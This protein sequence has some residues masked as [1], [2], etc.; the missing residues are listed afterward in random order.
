MRISDAIVE[1]LLKA[2]GKFSD[3][4][5]KPL[6]EQEKTE[7]KPLQDIVIKNSV[8]TEKELTKLYAE[9]IEVPYIEFN[10]RELS[11]DILKTTALYWRAIRSGIS[12]RISRLSSRGLNSI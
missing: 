10:P 1:K 11:R 6:R 3:E 9:E 4:Q 12:F 5:I 8:L 7:K 2:S